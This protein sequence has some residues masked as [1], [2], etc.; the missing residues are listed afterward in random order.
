L[1]GTLPAANPITCFYFALL[2]NDEQVR[3]HRG[4]Q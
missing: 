2:S 3:L 4:N 1:I